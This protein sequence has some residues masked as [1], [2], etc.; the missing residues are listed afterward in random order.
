MI[1]WWPGLGLCGLTLL[2]LVVGRGTTALDEWFFALGD[3]HP[4]LGRLLF[5]TDGRVMF[6]AAAIVLS[7][8]VIQRRWRLAAVVAAAPFVGV[9][10]SRLAKR[11]FD[12]YRD[13]AL[14]YPSGH[15]TLAVVIVGLALMVFGVTVWRSVAAAVVVALAV[16]GQGVSYHYFT[17]A[18]GALFL[19]SAVVCL[20]A[21]AA[22]LDRCQPGCDP[23]HSPG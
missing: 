2:G 22:G 3:A 7:A 13:D 17:D 21:W 15:T 12:R 10:L 19:G 20:A 9:A 14:A 11:L 1:R 6:V 4:T 8:A 5:V 18:I 23:D 16:L